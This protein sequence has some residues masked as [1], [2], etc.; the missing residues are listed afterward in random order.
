MHYYYYRQFY[1][2]VDKVFYY[3]RLVVAIVKY[4]FIAGDIYISVAEYGK[5]LQKLHYNAADNDHTRYI[6]LATNLTYQI[7]CDINVV[8]VGISLT[9]SNNPPSWSSNNTEIDYMN[10]EEKTSIGLVDSNPHVFYNTVDTSANLWLYKLNN[11]FIGRY[12]CAIN[13]ENYKD[14]VISIGR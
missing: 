4:H 8:S 1:V 2:R 14:I 9:N 11:S 3:N 12:R 5:S 7:K 10:T 13:T 6:E